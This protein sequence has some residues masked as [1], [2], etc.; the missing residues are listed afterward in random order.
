MS[1]TENLPLWTRTRA[2]GQQTSRAAA[3]RAF[4]KVRESQKEVLWIF[5][6]A[7]RLTDKEL[8]AIAGPDFKVHQSESGLRTRRSELVA[9][10]KI[11][12]SGETK[13]HNGGRRHIIWEIV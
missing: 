1:E 8:V 4:N 11:R 2:G 5:S 6:A 7:I 12:D 3:E 10:G 9:K 13:V